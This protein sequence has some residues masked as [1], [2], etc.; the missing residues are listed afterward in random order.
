MKHSFILLVA[1]TLALCSLQ[2]KTQ[3]QAHID[4]MAG[5][6][7]WSY[8]LFNDE[9]TISPDY[10]TSFSLSVDAPIEVTS[11]PTGWDF[12]TDNITYVQWFNTDQGLPYPHDIAPGTSMGGFSILSISAS[13]QQSTFGLESWDHVVDAPGFTSDGMIAAPIGA[14][15]V[16]EPGLLALFVSALLSCSGLAFVRHRSLQS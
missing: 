13:S 15:T 7:V 10:I 12:Q 2:A 11:S 6:P 5:P 9:P 16:P 8:T 3:L 1:L 14:T 4:S